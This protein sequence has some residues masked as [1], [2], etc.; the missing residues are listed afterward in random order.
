M[1]S[2]HLTSKPTLE[3]LLRLKRAERPAPEFWQQFERDLRRKQ[4]AATIEPKPWWLGLAILSRKAAPFGLPVGAAAALTLAAISFQT[5]VWTSGDSVTIQPELASAAPASVE[6]LL[7]AAGTMVAEVEAR[8]VAVDSR[9]ESSSAVVL[10]STGPMVNEAQVVVNVSPPSE[11]ELAPVEL[12]DIAL[13]SLLP[14]IG[15]PQSQV[16]EE[17]V[18]VEQTPSQRY[19]AQNLAIAQQQNPELGGAHGMRA[20][21]D[22]SDNEATP[23]VVEMSPRSARLLALVEAAPEGGEASRVAANIARE[24]AVRL[25]D[26]VLYASVTRLGVIGDRLSISF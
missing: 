5:G 22:I 16:A 12:A 8:P 18:S 11:L 7:P 10:A 19:I 21:L 15:L 6:A 1:K 9:P 14:G 2:P 24:Q 23:A 17:A 13:A 25:N 26:D 20:H 4:L 3:S